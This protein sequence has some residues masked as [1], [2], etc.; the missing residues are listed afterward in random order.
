MIEIVYTWPDGREE[1][2]YRRVAG[3]AA[4]A[5]LIAQVTALRERDGDKSPYSWRISMTESE[6]NER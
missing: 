6:R 5:H 2:R 1:V 3:T 4:A